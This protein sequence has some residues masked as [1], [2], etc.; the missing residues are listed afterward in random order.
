MNLNYN[1]ETGTFNW[2]VR[3]NGQLEQVGYYS[4]DKDCILIT[5]QDTPHKAHYLAAQL[6]LGAVPEHVYHLNGD[7]TDNRWSNLVV[8]NAP[9]WSNFPSVSR[10]YIKYSSKIKAWCV[11]VPGNKTKY[12]GTLTKAIQIRNLLVLG[13]ETLT[14]AA[15]RTERETLT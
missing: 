9:T 3:E 15:T 11:S 1:P 8:N 7:K 12:T 6:M 14:S 13:T 10:Q 2:I 5:L 4:K